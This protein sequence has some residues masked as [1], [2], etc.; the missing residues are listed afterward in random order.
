MY[1]KLLL[2]GITLLELNR[3]KKKLCLTLNSIMGFI[4]R[5]YFGFIESKLRQCNMQVETALLYQS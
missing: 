5:S 3:N 4:I 1:F 2:Y